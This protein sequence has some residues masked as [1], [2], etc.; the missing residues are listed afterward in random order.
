V[1]ALGM[2]LDRTRC[3]QCTGAMAQLVSS[4]T[5][6]RLVLDIGPLQLARVRPESALVTAIF[7][8]LMEIRAERNTLRRVAARAGS[9]AHRVFA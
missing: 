5:R 3:D 1:S 9:V 4:A 2:R 8:T 6:A 7:P